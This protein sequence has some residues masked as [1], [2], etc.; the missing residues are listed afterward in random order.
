MID[1]KAYKV[2]AKAPKIDMGDAWFEVIK[3]PKDVFA[4]VENGHVQEVC[5][6]LVIGS[7]K[8]LLFDT[9]MGISN[10]TKTIRQLTDLEIFVVNSHAHFDHIGDNWRFPD[11]HIFADEYAVDVLVK[12][13]S[14]WDVRYD[15]DPELFTKAYPPGF[16]PEKYF[17]K[18]VEKENIR[19]LHNGD[20]ID[21]GNR[22][23]EV[24]H[25]PGHSQESIMLFDRKNRALLTGDTYC[26]WL[27]AFFDSRMPKYGE[28]N[29]TTYTRTMRKIAELVPD[30]DYLYPSHGQ[31]LADPGM[32]S[33]AA[34]ALGKVVHGEADYYLEELYGATRRVYE[35]DSLLIWTS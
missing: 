31:P 24:L 25:T 8:A 16:D 22:Q 15:S 26:E 3:L 23:L 29:L 5:S 14:H 4:L 18:P 20:I 32:L 12:G 33:A 35:F 28:S 17:I 13:L 10:I 30:L 27:F 9:G 19:L 6:F 2:L 34:D 7:K 11:I 21:L 1:S